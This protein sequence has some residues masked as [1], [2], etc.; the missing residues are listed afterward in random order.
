M[1]REKRK[2]HCFID[3]ENVHESGFEGVEA[4]GVGDAVTIFISSVS[5][6][7]SLVVLD[8]LLR[9]NCELNIIH[10]I[11]TGKN[12]LD[13]QLIAEVGYQIGRQANEKLAPRFVI[14]SKDRGYEN[15][16]TVFSKRGVEIS[17]FETI[18]KIGQLIE[19][20]EESLKET[21]NSP[22]WEYAESVIKSLEGLKLTEAELSKIDRI[23]REAHTLAILHDRLAKSFGKRGNHQIYSKLKALHKQYQKTL[24]VIETACDEAPDTADLQADLTPEAVLEAPSPAVLPKESD[25]SEVVETEKATAEVK[26]KPRGRRKK[27][28]E[29]KHKADAEENAAEPKLPA[30]EQAAEVGAE[31]VGNPE[32]AAETDKP[33]EKK[34]RRPGRPRKKNG[35]SK[36][37]SE[38]NV[39]AGEEA[40]EAEKTEVN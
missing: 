24:P 5:H 36:S 7:I 26:K 40:S 33:V 14:I 28:A 29:E 3:Y 16:V 1:N 9:K 34:K 10:T 32:V 17:Q 15:V 23:F 11:G 25:Q 4:L 27:P 2:T 37:A 13:F 19:N 38:T 21:H 22:E 31:N 20:C 8:T 6:K 30:E 18:A 35:S 12:N 39:Q